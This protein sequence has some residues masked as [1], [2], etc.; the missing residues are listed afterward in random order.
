MTQFEQFGYYFYPSTYSP[1]LGHASVDVFLA[2]CENDWFFPT[3]TAAF[4]VADDDEGVHHLHVTHS[5]TLGQRSYRL[6][7]GIFFLIACDGD[8]VEGFSFGGDLT[9]DCEDDHIKCQLRSSAP[10][11]D[12]SDTTEL[13]TILVPEFEAE[14]GRLRAG[15]QGPDEEFD[16]RVAAADPFALF[17]VSLGLSNAYAH[18]LPALD[19]DQYLLDDRQAVRRAV[20]TLQK[21]GQWPATPVTLHQMIFGQ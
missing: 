4:P 14:L 16:R 3:K 10:F 5:W 2:V 17:V 19:S 12:L 13:V 6:A 21:A 1:P 18:R 11:F 9:V 7:P 8:L 20:H 15:W